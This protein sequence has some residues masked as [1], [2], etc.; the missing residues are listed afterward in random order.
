MTSNQ[1]ADPATNEPDD[2][3]VYAKVT[4]QGASWYVIAESEQRQRCLICRLVGPARWVDMSACELVKRYLGTPL[5][6]RRYGRKGLV[7]YQTLGSIRRFIADLKRQEARGVPAC[8]AC[9]KR[10]VLVHD[11]EDGQA[12]CLACCDMPAVS[13]E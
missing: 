7:R 6:P 13:G 4:Y 2:R 1:T 11:R 10:G 5:N 12:K 3:R 9:G 8:P